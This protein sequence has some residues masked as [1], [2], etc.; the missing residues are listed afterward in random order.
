MYYTDLISSFKLMAQGVAAVFI[1][2]AIIFVI[3]Y[4]S[5]KSK[6]GAE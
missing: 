3:V 2:M 4:L 1:V 5:A 6:G